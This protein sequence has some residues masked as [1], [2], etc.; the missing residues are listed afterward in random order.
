MGH[1]HRHAFF[2]LSHTDKGSSRQSLSTVEGRQVSKLDSR[3]KHSFFFMGESTQIIRWY[4]DSP[5]QLLLRSKSNADRTTN[6]PSFFDLFL[7][8][9]WVLTSQQ[10]HPSDWLL[11]GADQH[12]SLSAASSHRPASQPAAVPP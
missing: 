12:L 5:D 1:G 10:P 11:I 7:F 4:C 3:E 9:L 6:Q 2:L 8:F